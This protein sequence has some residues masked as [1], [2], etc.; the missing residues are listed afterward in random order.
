VE[1]AKK[2][3][4]LLP[5]ALREPKKDSAPAQ[6]DPPFDE[7]W[8]ERKKAAALI[9]DGVTVKVAEAPQIYAGKKW[10]LFILT[11]PGISDRVFHVVKGNWYY[12][13]DREGQCRA[14][15]AAP[16]D[17]VFKGEGE[18]EVWLH[19]DVEQKRMAV[20]KFRNWRKESTDPLN[21]G[22]TPITASMLT[23]IVSLLAQDGE[24]VYYAPR[25]LKECVENGTMDAEVVR[26]ATQILLQ[27]PAVSPAKLVRVLEN[28]IRL[29]PTLWPML[30][31]C[32]KAAGAKV[33]GGEAPPVWVNRVLGIALRYAP[34]LAEAAKRGIIP[35]DDAQWPGLADIAATKKKSAAVGK[36]KEL[37]A[38]K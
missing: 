12:D 33:T 3:A 18:N 19:W 9:E 30:T 1:V 24:A 25:M 11:L 20:S 27:S 4:N 8:P 28:D 22:S 13:L 29:L 38:L 16:G 21:G 10:F 37:M 7:I 2:V 36:A 17:E 34:Y 5:P 23:I 26:K 14:Y 15:V 35:P 6:M 32:V 31:E